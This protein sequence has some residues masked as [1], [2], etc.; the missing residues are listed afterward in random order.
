MNITSLHQIHRV[1]CHRQQWSIRP[2]KLTITISPSTPLTKKP[3]SRLMEDL[4]TSIATSA[5][6]I[7]SSWK[8]QCHEATVQLTI[9]TSFSSPHAKM[10][11]V[12]SGSIGQHE[13][14][15]IGMEKG[16]QAQ[17][18]VKLPSLL[19]VGEQDGG[20]EGKQ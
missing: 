16:K 8:A 13:G 20:R 14:Q 7:S 12:D 1:Q 3:S 15:E 2:L 10:V 11:E 18:Q 6:K 5:T 4:D 9:P 17:A 19:G